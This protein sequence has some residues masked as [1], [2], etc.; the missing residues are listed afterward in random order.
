MVKNP[1]NGCVSKILHG[2]FSA[3]LFDPKILLFTDP[4]LLLESESL[5]C[6]FIDGG[7]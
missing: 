4:I 3:M 6:A 2:F 5:V 7:S 1:L